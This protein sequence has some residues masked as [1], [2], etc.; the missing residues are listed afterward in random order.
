MLDL[1]D[2]EAV[3]N[4]LEGVEIVVH[5]VTC[6][7]EEDREQSEQELLDWVSPIYIRPN[8]GSLQRGRRIVLLSTLDLM[9]SYD[10][11]YIVTTDWQPASPCECGCAGTTYGRAHWGAK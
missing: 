3:S 1:T 2:S 10:E 4:V 5:A 7:G 9:R 11:R 6:T 8:Y